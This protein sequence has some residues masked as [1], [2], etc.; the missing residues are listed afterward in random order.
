M[1]VLWNQAIDVIYLV[2]QCFCLWNG[3]CRDTPVKI[4]SIRKPYFDENQHAMHPGGI[5][6]E[7]GDYTEIH[8]RLSTWHKGGRSHAILCIYQDF[9]AVYQFRENC[10]ISDGIFTLFFYSN[11]VQ[12]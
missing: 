4:H 7:L 3:K 11:N 9:S 10:K 12:S 5:F 2:K 8:H 1:G 6:E